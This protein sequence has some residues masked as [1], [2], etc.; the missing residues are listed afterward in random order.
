[1]QY[2]ANAGVGVTRCGDPGRRIYPFGQVNF[3]CL[4]PSTADET[5]DDPTVRRCINF[6]KSWAFGSLVVTNIFA[7]RSTDPAA[8]YS[9]D[10]P[11]PVGR[12]NNDW[13][14]GIAVESDLVIA[15]W[16]VHGRHLGRSTR[17]R[18]IL[19]EA[20]VKLHYLRLGKLEPWHPLYLPAALKPIEWSYER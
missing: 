4:N 9:A 3:I 16:G 11:D 10:T 20:G 17:V 5:N 7:W 8:L 19:A 18:E 12:Y 1:M 14:R 6:A 15:A 13:I 2:S